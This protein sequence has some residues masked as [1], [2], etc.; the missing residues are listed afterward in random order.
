MLYARIVPAAKDIGLWGPRIR[1]AFA[2]MG[3][4]GYAQIPLEKLQDADEARARQIES[5][6]QHVAGTIAFCPSPPL[7]N[8]DPN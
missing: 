7:K 2:R 8:R 6:Q 4:M 3:L 1:Q 5:R